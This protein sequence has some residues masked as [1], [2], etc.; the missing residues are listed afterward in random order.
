MAAGQGARILSE[1]IPPAD[2]RSARWICC[3]ISREPFRHS[4]KRWN[5]RRG[6][7]M[8]KIGHQRRCAAV[9][10]TMCRAAMSE[11]QLV[12]SRAGA[13]QRSRY[14]YISGGPQS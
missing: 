12:I 6:F 5:A 13:F 1:V 14:L 3:A 7:L 10:P 11:A 4:T 8:P 9:F 2:R